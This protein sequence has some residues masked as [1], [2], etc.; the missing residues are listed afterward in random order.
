MSNL[1]KRPSALGFLT[2]A[3]Y[4]QKAFPRKRHT[5]ISLSQGP[6]SVSSPNHCAPLVSPGTPRTACAA[7][8]FACLCCRTWVAKS[9]SRT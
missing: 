6:T 7:L 5:S 9:K 4:N 3:A 1:S 8:R 2:R